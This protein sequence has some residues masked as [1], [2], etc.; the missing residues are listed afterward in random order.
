VLSATLDLIKEPGAVMQITHWLKSLFVIAKDNPQ[1]MR[2]QLRALSR[3]I[4]LMYFV[5]I[6][7]TIALSITHASTAPL[8]LTVLFPGVLI[9]LSVARL[10]GWWRS[11]D[12]EISPEMAYRRLRGSLA[13]GAVLGIAFTACA[14]SLYS[15][16][17]DAA[18]AH[19]AFYI[20]ITCIACIFCLTTLRPAA[21]VLVLVV[22]GPSVVFFATTGNLV[23]IA[24]ALNLLLVTGALTIVLFHNFE[25]L[26]RSVVSQQQLEASNAEM[27][28]LSAENVRLANLDS[29]TGLP[30]RRRFFAELDQAIALHRDTGACVTVGIVDLDGFKPVN[31]L[32]GHA[33]GDRVLVEVGRRLAALASPTS[34]LARL[35]G[36]EFAYILH[37]ERSEEEILACGRLICDALSAPYV[38]GDLI[39]QLSA[40]VGFATAAALGAGSESLLECADY[41]LYDAKHTAP[42]T[43]QL[44]SSALQTRLRHDSLVEQGLRHPDLPDQLS[45]NYQPIFDAQAGR[46][47]G[48]EALARW[49]SPTLGKV[50]PDVFIRA[51]ERTGLITQLTQTLL[52]RAL[53]EAK[54]W[55]ADLRLSFNLS[56]QDIAS[57]QAIGRIIDLVQQSGLAPTRIDFEITETA[58][59]RDFEQSCA[60]LAQLRALGARIA[61]DDFGSGYSSLSYVHRL[62]LDKIKIDRGFIA[63]LEAQDTS[64]NILRSMLDLCR[65]LKL[66]CVVEGAETAGQVAIL[67]QLG[68][69]YL[70]GYFIS[71]PIQA[72]AIPDFLAIHNAQLRSAG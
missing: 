45:L 69:R 63:E 54:A 21:L 17:D 27:A 55:P 14:L 58:V 43:P 8:A 3:H 28:A 5:L 51:A 15:Y 50:P 34:V 25:H 41:A 16:G 42:G 60:A 7:N 57:P 10:I 13:F 47:I 59:M 6:T 35:G 64:R 70:Q 52:A 26:T 40:T 72:D 61:L 31:D 44:F 23:F 49:T 19:V 68:C 33:L 12:I 46:P 71:R 36:D 18:R 37:G 4:P 48:F 22:V 67:T 2:V 24:M 66:E 20:S 38:L 62:P 53:A 39:V 11:R 1:L 30:N 9:A 32:Y 29:L 56:M 65:N